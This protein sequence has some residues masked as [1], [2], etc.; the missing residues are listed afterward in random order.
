M[1]D[2]FEEMGWEPLKN[3]ETPNNMLQMARFLIEFQ[4]IEP[5]SPLAP[6]ASRQFVQQL[7]SPIISKKGN[8]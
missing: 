2:Y 7:P 3:G 4:Y 5:E 6:P 8:V 1:A